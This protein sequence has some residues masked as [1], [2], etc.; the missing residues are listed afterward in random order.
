[1]TIPTVEALVAAI[2]AAFRRR[3]ESSETFRNALKGKDRVI[4]LNVTDGEHWHLVVKDGNLVET[5]RGA[6]GKADVVITATTRDLLAVANREVHPV[7]AYMSGQV[8]VKAPLKD[9][10]VVKGFLG[11]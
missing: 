7:R 2:E 5:A 10:L 8:K 1:M 4:H 6:P 9:I 11:K 3:Y